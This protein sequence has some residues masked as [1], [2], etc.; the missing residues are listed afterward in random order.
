VRELSVRMVALAEEVALGTIPDSALS[1]RL[2]GQEVGRGVLP[3]GSLTSG[4]LGKVPVRF[5]LYDP[6]V[7]TSI[8]A[9][10]TLQVHVRPASG[11]AAARFPLTSPR[12]R[13]VAQLERAPL[14]L[15]R[16]HTF[17]RG[18]FRGAHGG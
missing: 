12:H 14:A 5:A 11:D 9:T 6:T 16:A 13:E 1:L 17:E 15:E 10:G 8:V 3:P 7:R 4:G 18:R 2:G